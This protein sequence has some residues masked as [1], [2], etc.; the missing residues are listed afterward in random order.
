LSQTQGY[1]SKLAAHM[2]LEGISRWRM[3]KLSCRATQL[4][5]LQPMCFQEGWAFMW[6]ARQR[7]STHPGNKGAEDLRSRYAAHASSTEAVVQFR[8]GEAHHRVL[9]RAGILHR[10][11]PVTGILAVIEAESTIHRTFMTAPE[12]RALCTTSASRLPARTRKMAMGTACTWTA[13]GPMLIFL[14]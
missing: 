5:T 10:R 14:T 3:D 1:L 4:I 9:G 11:M 12:G 13:T 8:S 6:I 7:Q 2:D